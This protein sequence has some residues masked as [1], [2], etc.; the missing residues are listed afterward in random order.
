MN[1]MGNMNQLG[2]FLAVNSKAI[3][4][5]LMGFAAIMVTLEQWVLAGSALSCLLLHILHAIR[6]HLRSL[7]LR[8]DVASTEWVVEINRVK[9]ARIT[10]AD[11]AGITRSVLCDPMMYLRQAQN[12]AYVIV[13]VVITASMAIPLFGFW[14]VVLLVIYDQNAVTVWLD[15]NQQS[16]WS[17]LIDGTSNLLISIMV[18]IIFMTMS[19]A[20]LKPRLFGFVNCIDEAIAV[21]LKRHCN[22]ALSDTP[23]LSRWTANGKEFNQQSFLQ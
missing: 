1:G 23:V 14:L 9:V 2:I 8:K 22:I 5:G 17:W 4:A 18:A 15:A 7:S 19:I 21:R 13:K 6:V 3:A 11:Y 16:G 12:L 10:D 20:L